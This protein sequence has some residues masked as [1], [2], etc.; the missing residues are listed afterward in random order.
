MKKYVM[1][2]L[3]GFSVLVVIIL[4]CVLIAVLSN[5]LARSEKHIKKDL[6]TLTPIGTSMEDVIAAVEKNEKWKIV[7][8]NENSG[9][10]IDE[11]GKADNNTYPGVS[12]TVV[13]VKS[14]EVLL[15]RD[16][17]LGIFYLHYVSV[18]YG[19]DENSNLINIAVK[20]EVDWL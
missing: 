6:L 20:K 14:I 2:G 7:C 17:I 9:Y 10:F 1:F 19:F 8:I 12:Y 13:G 18:W 11:N 4:A 3:V 5:P 15:G 16:D